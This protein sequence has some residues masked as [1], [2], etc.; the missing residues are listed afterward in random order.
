[1]TT[2]TTISST[3]IIIIIIIIIFLFSLTAAQSP[4]STQPSD[5]PLT[6]PA[7]FRPSIA[8]VIGIFSI[9]FSLTF[10]LLMYVKFCNNSDSEDLFGR[11]T[12]SDHLNLP[13]GH[14]QSRFSGIDKNIIDSLPFFRF[15]SLKG[16][17]EG[18]ECAVCLSRFEDTEVL[19]LLPKCKHA[20][21]IDCVDKWLES[22]SSCP[23]CRCKVDVEDLSLFKY[24][25]SSRSMR[26]SESVVDENIELF[27]E[28]E[29]SVSAAS[30]KRFGSFRRAD[31]QELLIPDKVKHR[32]FVSEVAMKN[33]WSDVNSSDLMYL[34]SEMI[35][36]STSQRFDTSGSSSSNNDGIVKIKEEMEKKRVLKSEDWRTGFDSRVLTSPGNQRSMSEITNL[37]RLG[38]VRNR[39]NNIGSSSDSKE[40]KVRRVWVPI[41]RRT[42]QWLAGRERRS[43]QPP[44][45]P[46][47]EEEE[48]NV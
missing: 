20:F 23:L 18:L 22:H 40:E 2:L 43:E 11:P 31:K 42:V 16:S 24:P 46:P 34:N 13:F 19:R 15:S 36:A 12:Q 10:L 44:P 35:G 39:E 6:P 1:M 5:D 30:S 7:S 33:R 47:P 32:I 38:R 14:H 21:H 29:G 27:V 3:S 45:P 4:P 48:S 8:I 9:M 28:R 17:R 37:S 41:A 25:H 26:S